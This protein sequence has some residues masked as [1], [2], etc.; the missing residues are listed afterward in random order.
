MSDTKKDKQ[1][2]IV[3]H[4]M[5][6]ETRFGVVPTEEDEVAIKFHWS[7]KNVPYEDGPHGAPF[8]PVIEK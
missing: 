6:G 3:N 5:A 4:I 1:H 7:P 2:Q 8:N